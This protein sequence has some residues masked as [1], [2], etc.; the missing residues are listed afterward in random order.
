MRESEIS[1]TGGVD[2]LRDKDIPRRDVAVH[3]TLQFC[4]AHVCCE[5]RDGKLPGISSAVGAVKVAAQQI[6]QLCHV[7]QVPDRLQRLMVANQLAEERS[8]RLHK[9]VGR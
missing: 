6:Y 7:T 4:V 8:L 1:T 3:Q 9:R 5:G 2:T